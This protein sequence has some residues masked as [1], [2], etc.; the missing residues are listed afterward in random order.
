MSKR[1]WL[2]FGAIAAAVVAV[3]FV[4]PHQAA[5]ENGP[6]GPGHGV[7]AAPTGSAPEVGLRTVRLRVRGM[8]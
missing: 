8:T 4:S 3:Q 5:H 6:H 1:E 7:V 2:L